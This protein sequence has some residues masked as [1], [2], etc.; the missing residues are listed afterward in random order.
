MPLVWM[1]DCFAGLGHPLI[2]LRYLMLTLVED[3]IH[4]GGTIAPETT[5]TYFRM[6]WG[7][8]LSD[9]DLKRYAKS[10]AE[11]AQAHG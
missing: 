11:L 8:G 3:A 10:A 5:A 4:E 2:S 9:G 6:V 1:R 7:G